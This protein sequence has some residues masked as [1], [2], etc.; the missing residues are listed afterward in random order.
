MANT[1]TNCTYLCYRDTPVEWQGL[2]AFASHGPPTDSQE[3]KAI[4]VR[5]SC[6]C[7]QEVGVL[8]VRLFQ[9]KNSTWI[10][11][12][13][14][15]F[16]AYCQAQSVFCTQPLPMRRGLK[17]HQAGTTNFSRCSLPPVVPLSYLRQALAGSVSRLHGHHRSSKPS[18]C[19]KKPKTSNQNRVSVHTAKTSILREIS[20]KCH[21]SSSDHHHQILPPSPM[22][23][24]PAMGTR[25]ETPGRILLL[26]RSYVVC[27]ELISRLLK[28][29]ASEDLSKPTAAQ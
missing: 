17:Q 13:H 19:M 18:T 8:S 23:P 2:S 14:G 1:G 4:Y 28:W 10:P 16:L 5:S 7:P 26:S 27:L 21:L 9:Y 22:F 24:Q 11:L 3:G 15:P 29:I 20:K 25:I 6:C 12:A